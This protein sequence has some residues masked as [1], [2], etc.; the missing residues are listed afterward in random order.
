MTSH[1]D[2]SFHTLMVVLKR[3]D[4]LDVGQLEWNDLRFWSVT[5]E[6]VTLDAR[7]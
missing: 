5:E 4:W 6:W 1:P 7:V 2:Q 3:A